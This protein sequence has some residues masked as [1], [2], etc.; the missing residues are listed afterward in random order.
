MRHLHG[1]HTLNYFLPPPF[2]HSPPSPSPATTTDPQVLDFD[3]FRNLKL[4][5]DKRVLE[6]MKLAAPT[7]QARLLEEVLKDEILQE[8]GGGAAPRGTAS[9]STSGYGPGAKRKV[10]SRGALTGAEG[11][12][13]AEFAARPGGHT[14]PA[15]QPAKRHKIFKQYH[16]GKW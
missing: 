13:Y 14:A 5:K 16:G 11:L 8:V 12:H 6:R 1:T 9:A 15:G 2:P 3:T 4:G 7:A 10:G